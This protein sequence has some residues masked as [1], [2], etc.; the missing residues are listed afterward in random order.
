MAFGKDRLP[1]LWL[2]RHNV[3]LVWV[4]E[5]TERRLPALRQNPWWGW[6][7]RTGVLRRRLLAPLRA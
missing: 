5:F 6:G 3:M 2:G 1:G 7:G 4:Q